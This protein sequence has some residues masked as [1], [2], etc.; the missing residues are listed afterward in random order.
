MTRHLRPFGAACA[1]AVL[2]AACVEVPDTVRAAFAPAAPGDPSNYR[3]GPHGAAPP[4]DV[5]TAIIASAT[6]D[7]S[8]EAGPVV[9]AAVESVAPDAAVEPAADTDAA[10]T[11]TSA[12]GE[13]G[14]P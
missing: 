14:A 13:G 11:P 1:V 8:T 12:D 10:V 2:L 4:A 5:G 7:A 6:F 9:D 3:I